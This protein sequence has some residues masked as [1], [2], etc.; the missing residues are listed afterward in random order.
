MLCS[1]PTPVRLLLLQVPLKWS[2]GTQISASSHHYQVNSIRAHAFD[3]GDVPVFRV[4]MNSAL[5]DVAI[6]PI[7]FAG[8]APCFLKTAPVPVCPAVG[9]DNRYRSAGV[10]P[11]EGLYETAPQNGGARDALGREGIAV[12]SG[13]YDS[14]LIARVGRLGL[15]TSSNSLQPTAPEHVTLLRQQGKID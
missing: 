9:F 7:P 15:G 11:A 8:T 10:R 4:R 12:L 2:T 14:E 3:K 5:K 6:F 1:R 13:T